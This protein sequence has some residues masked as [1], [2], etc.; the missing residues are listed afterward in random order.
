MGGPVE[1]HLVRGKKQHML[2]IEEFNL[3]RVGKVDVIS[4]KTIPDIVPFP[5]PRTPQLHNR[6]HMVHNSS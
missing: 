6:I 1:S 3:G 5:M 2:K 4:V